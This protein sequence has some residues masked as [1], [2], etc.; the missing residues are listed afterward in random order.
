MDLKVHFF[1]KTHRKAILTKIKHSK[2]LFL[3]LVQLT[4]NPRKHRKNAQKALTNLS[5]V[6]FIKFRAPARK[7][8]TVER[9]FLHF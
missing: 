4:Q 3:I 8:S 9:N 5:G 1:F 6:L 7:F 2:T